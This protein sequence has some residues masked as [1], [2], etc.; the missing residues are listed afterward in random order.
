[1]EVFCKSR[2]FCEG[3]GASSGTLCRVERYVGQCVRGRQSQ[4]PRPRY[5][6]KLSIDMSERKL[7]RWIRVETLP[8]TVASGAAPQDAV[9]FRGTASMSTMSTMLDS[10]HRVDIDCPPER[11]VQGAQ[12]PGIHGV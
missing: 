2:A 10:S 7:S 6:V 9:G 8:P 3:M 11:Q 4:A 5:D 12:L 1:M